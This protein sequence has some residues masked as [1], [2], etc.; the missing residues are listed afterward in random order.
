VIVYTSFS[1]GMWMIRN[2]KIIFVVFIFLNLYPCETNIFASNTDSQTRKYIRNSNELNVKKRKVKNYTNESRGRKIKSLIKK[3]SN[4]H[5]NKKR[6]DITMSN[7]RGAS[8][9]TKDLVKKNRWFVKKPFKKSYNKISN[10]KRVQRPQ[11]DSGTNNGISWEVSKYSKARARETSHKKVD[12]RTSKEIGLKA[13][14]Y[15]KARAREASH[16]K[17]DSGT[18][19]EISLKAS[20]YS[21]TRA[22]ET[23]PKKPEI[24]FSEKSGR[25]AMDISKTRARETGTVKPQI[26]YSDKVSREAYKMTS[27]REKRKLI[28]KTNFTGQRYSAELIKSMGRPAHIK[29]INF[30]LGTTTGLEKS[31]N[32]K[33]TF[34]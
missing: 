26:I 22:R 11:F 13:S 21:K 4:T 20:K 9:T 17:I 19:K 8:L 25:V 29:K 31:N 1:V 23:G 6:N 27:K 32:D 2:L 12:P 10:I 34:D 16:K 30:S 15:S 24:V 28:P 14:K 7:M 3:E 5:S 18:N 33:K